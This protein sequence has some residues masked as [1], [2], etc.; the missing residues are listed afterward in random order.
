MVF[1]KE[2]VPKTPIYDTTSGFFD[3]TMGA[4]DGAEACEILGTYMLSLISKKYIKK[5]FGLYRDD[6]LGVVKN[7][8][9]PETEKIKKNTQ[10]IFKENK[11][12]IVF[13][14]T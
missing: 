6:G 13:N 9:G 3:V 7:K 1:K 4:H 12:D 11:L 8:C 2:S 5:D 14:A 10:K